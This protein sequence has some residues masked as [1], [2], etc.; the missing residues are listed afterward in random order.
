[1]SLLNG[2]N[3][4]T[5]NTN[6]YTTKVDTKKTERSTEKPATSEVAKE[7]AKTDETVATNANGDT[8]EISKKTEDKTSKKISQEELAKIMKDAEKDAKQF[9]NFINKVMGNQGKNSII[10]NFGKANGG[11]D[12][13]FSMTLEELT[14]S[15]AD[16]KAG[17]EN[18]TIQVDQ[19]TIDKAKELTSED[20]YYGVKQTSER[21]LD[22]AKAISGG[23]T[24]KAD[25]LKDAIQKGFD[26]AA[27]L[28]GGMDKAPQITKDTYDAVMKGFDEW[29]NGASTKP[30]T[31]Q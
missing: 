25:V 29:V 4:S 3:T 18:G 17:L 11:E 27:E 9:T 1:M 7:T 16:L 10:A 24:S 13:S 5:V 20:G 14:S 31:A 21:I 23:D 28:W 30:T 22:F 8:L 15:V 12:D 19:E 2:I 26:S 6:T